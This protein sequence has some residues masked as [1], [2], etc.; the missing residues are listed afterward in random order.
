MDNDFNPQNSGG[1]NSGGPGFPP[2]NYL[3]WAILS[4]I[5]CCLPLGVVSIIKSTEVNSKWQRGD[6]DGAMRSSADAKKFAMWGA[7]AAGIGVVLY[8]LFIVILGLGAA[9]SN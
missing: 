7:I 8:V 6:Y 1:N 9:L 4:T 2:E 3:V 5:F